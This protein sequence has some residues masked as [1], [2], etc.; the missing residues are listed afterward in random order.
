[1][2]YTHGDHSVRESQHSWVTGFEAVT[3]NPPALQACDLEDME[4]LITSLTF[5]PLL[6]QNM[7]YTNKQTSSAISAANLAT[8]K[9]DL[10]SGIEFYF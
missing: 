10:D 3:K 7:L 6:T 9:P 5:I 2:V 1:M 8:L 4:I